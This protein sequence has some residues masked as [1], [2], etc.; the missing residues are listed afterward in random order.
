MS[1]SLRCPCPCDV[2]TGWLVM[3]LPSEWQWHFSLQPGSKSQLAERDTNS[4]YARLPRSDEAERPRHLSSSWGHTAHFCEVQH[5]YPDLPAGF[6]QVHVHLFH[7][8]VALFTVVSCFLDV[9]LGSSSSELWVW[10]HHQCRPWPLLHFPLPQG[11]TH[12]ASAGT[13][14]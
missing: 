11:T 12:L 9:S 7:L 14:I 6:H 10:N 13:S 8:A 3:S 1:R 5:P 2:L 4:T